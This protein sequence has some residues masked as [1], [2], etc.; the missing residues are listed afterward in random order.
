MQCPKCKNGMEKKTLPYANKYRCTQCSYKR[1]CYKTLFLVPISTLFLLLLSVQA[2][3]PIQTQIDRFPGQSVEIDWQYP[4][5]FESQVKRYAIMSGPSQTGPWTLFAT[6]TP[7]TTRSYQFSAGDRTTYY[8]LAAY[9]TPT[10]V[11]GETNGGLS[12][13]PIVVR[14]VSRHRWGWRNRGCRQ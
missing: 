1:I 14:C 8:A 7:G 9:S 2:Q 11:A 10:P 4:A 3:P 13:P 6:V 12:S 5:N